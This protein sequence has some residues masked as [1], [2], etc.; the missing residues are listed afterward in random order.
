MLGRRF[1]VA[2][3]RRV[4]GAMPLTAVRW[5]GDEKTGDRTQPLPL[6]F[7]HADG[8]KQPGT[9]YVGQTLMEA[10]LENGLVIEAAC[11]GSCACSTCHMYLDEPTYEAIPEPTDRELDMLDLAFYPEPTS[12]LSCQVK[13]TKSMAGM[14]A[15][16][17]KATRNMAV[18]GY[19]AKPH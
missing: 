4:A 5:H 19:V 14:E 9:A 10:A 17:P 6:T 8:K 3:T 2:T 13:M 12:R 15:K 16:L 18:D 1:V 7:V 11:G